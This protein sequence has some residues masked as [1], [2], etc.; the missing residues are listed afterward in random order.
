MERFRFPLQ[1]AWPR[2]RTAEVRTE[3]L[4]HSLVT[5]ER[6]KTLRACAGP[7]A[8]RL[9][10]QPRGAT[11]RCCAVSTQ[12][13]AFHVRGLEHWCNVLSLAPED[14]YQALHESF[15]CTLEGGSWNALDKDQIGPPNVTH[16]AP[17]SSPTTSHAL[18]HTLH[19]SFRRICYFLFVWSH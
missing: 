19:Q 11:G 7:A 9:G 4:L 2:S 16:M 6:S 15:S 3:I 8:G 13:A 10:R 18:G 5:V 14:A 1:T 12:P 17:D